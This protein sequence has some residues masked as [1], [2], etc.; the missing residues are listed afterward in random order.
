MIP[1]KKCESGAGQPVRQSS[2]A[3][4]EPSGNN[5]TASYRKQWCVGCADEKADNDQHRDQLADRRIH[6]D[7]GKYVAYR[8]KIRVNEM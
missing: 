8:G 2:A 5:T 1:I 3:Y 7:Y 4:R 6:L